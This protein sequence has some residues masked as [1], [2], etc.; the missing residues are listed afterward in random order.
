MF[1]AF[2]MMK[3][4]S[5]IMTPKVYGHLSI[6]S[7]EIAMRVRGH[8]EV[9]EATYYTHVGN[10]ERSLY[11][12]YRAFLRT[13]QKQVAESLGYAS[14]DDALA[15]GFEVSTNVKDVIKLAMKPT[16]TEI[17]AVYC[18]LIQTRNDAPTN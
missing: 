18:N 11:R 4:G 15:D 8:K 17:P 5:H 7:M 14:V 6:M 16:V 9:D 3:T 13:R 2:E 12:K 1:I 10:F